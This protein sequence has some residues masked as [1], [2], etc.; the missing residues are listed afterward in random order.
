MMHRQL[1]RAAVI[2][3]GSLLAL[4]AVASTQSLNVKPGLWEVTSITQSSGMPAMDLSKLPRGQRAQIEAAMKKQMAERA[5]PKTA[6]EC[7]TKEKIEKE[8]FQDKDMDPSCKRTSIAN[9]PALQELKIEC[10]GAQKM[11]GAM[12]FEAINPENVKGTVKMAAERPGQTM[13]VTSSFTAKWL[14]PDCGDVK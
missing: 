12:R 5:S 4:S 3:G 8:L 13:N 9:T 11:T 1:S 14:G 10:T 6:R 7:M 2:A